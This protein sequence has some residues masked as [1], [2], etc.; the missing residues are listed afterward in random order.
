MQ[1]SFIAFFLLILASCST[2]NS[3]SFT[4]DKRVKKKPITVVV[5]AGHG[6]KDPGAHSLNAPRVNEKDVALTTAL[7]LRRH[8]MRRGYDVLMTRHDDSFVPLRDRAL[9]PQQIAR[10]QGGV[11]FVSVHYN[12]AKNTQAS[13]VEV[14]YYKS[15]EASTRRQSSERLA[16]A[17]LEEIV[18]QTKMINRGVKHG[19]FCVVRETSV[20]AILVE[21]GF[22]SNEQDMKRLRQGEY[23]NQVAGSIAKGLD[24][25]VEQ[26]LISHVTQ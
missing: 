6:G 24:T 22:M 26:T 16:S 10:P 25:Y 7:L 13:G 14:Y 5:D 11:L 19:N 17:V 4:V 15:K 9:F 8:L 12:A 1:R 18:A 20:P 3:G 21:G 23:L 2:V